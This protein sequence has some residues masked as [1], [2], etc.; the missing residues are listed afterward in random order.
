VHLA[1]G[2]QSDALM[3]FEQYRSQLMAELGI[4]PTAHLTEIIRSIQ[5]K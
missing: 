5:R 1:R 2:N 3:A 4:E